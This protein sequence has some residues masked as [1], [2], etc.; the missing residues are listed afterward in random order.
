MKTLIALFILILPVYSAT[1]YV[2][3]NGSDSNNGSQGSPWATIG[4]ALSSSAAGDTVNIASRLEGTNKT[5][6]THIL[7]NHATAQLVQE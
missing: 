3:P 2:A 7:I 4:K 6:G 1:Y 5:Y